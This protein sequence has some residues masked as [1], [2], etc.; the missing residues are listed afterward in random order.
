MTSPFNNN[1]QS[2]GSSLKSQNIN[3]SNYK[4]IINNIPSTTSITYTTNNNINN[5]IN[6][7]QIG[8]N[9]Q[10]HYGVVN[11]YQQLR[12]QN[13]PNFIPLKHGIK[14]SISP[15]PYP[16]K[17]NYISSGQYYN[18]NRLFN[19]NQNIIPIN[20]NGNFN[21]SQPIQKNG[22]YLYNAP[23]FYSSSGNNYKSLNN[24]K[25]TADIGVFNTYVPYIG[26]DEKVNGEKQQI[27]KKPPIKKPDPKIAK[28]KLEEKI[29]NENKNML[30]RQHQLRYQFLKKNFLI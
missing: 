11:N 1:F 15:Q 18:G 29:Q 7:N 13:N 26:E 30:E 8:S 17:N 21:Y 20:F 27:I 28:Q 12:V 4:D 22:N 2:Q 6:N 16:S 5:N 23:N 19:N 10:I 9:K 14:R 24:P 3:F 25:Y